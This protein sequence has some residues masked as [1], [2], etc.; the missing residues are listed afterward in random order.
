MKE[1]VVEGVAYRKYRVAFRLTDGKR[2]AWVRWSPGWPWIQDELAREF[3]DKDMPIKP[4]SLVSIRG[5][6]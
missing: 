5:M 4:G 1:R 6:P 3:Q 2:R